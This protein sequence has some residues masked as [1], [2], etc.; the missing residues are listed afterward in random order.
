ME[1]I[2]ARDRSLLPRG[3]RVYRQDNIVSQRPPGDFPVEFEGRTYRPITGYWK[4]GTE[5]MA[6]LIAARRI[7]TRGKMLSY[8]RYFDDFPYSPIANFWSDVRFSSRS[9]QKQYVVQTTPKS[10]NVAFS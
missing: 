10:W 7:E 6:K 9:E 3:S 8:V 1:E 2:E 5:G 4:T